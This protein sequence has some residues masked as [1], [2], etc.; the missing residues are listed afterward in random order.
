MKIN[1]I[2]SAPLCVEKFSL[3]FH[4][5]FITIPPV[6]LYLY[7]LCTKLRSA[8]FFRTLCLWKIDS[9]L[10]KDLERRFSSCLSLDHLLLIMTP[11]YKSDV[12]RF[13]L[14]IQFKYFQWEETNKV[15]KRPSWAQLSNTNTYYYV[16][17][18]GE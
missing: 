7:L 6:Y 8:F 16:H 10:P 4:L 3:I 2:H 14:W 17:A 9:F 12:C 1:S 13:L 15:R 18:Q 5:Q 11:R